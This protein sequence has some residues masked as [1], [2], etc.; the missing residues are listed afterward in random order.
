MRRAYICSKALFFLPTMSLVTLVTQSSLTCVTYQMW[1]YLVAV[2]AGVSIRKGMGSFWNILGAFLGE[3]CIVK[4]SKGDEIITTDKFHCCSTKI[5]IVGLTERYP[6][7]WTPDA[8]F[9]ETCAEY[10][11][12]ETAVLRDGRAQFAN[13]YIQAHSSKLF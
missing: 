13:V 8:Q 10:F 9:F 12:W 6:P 7:P 3:F 5:T 1:E 11:F 2:E 4:I